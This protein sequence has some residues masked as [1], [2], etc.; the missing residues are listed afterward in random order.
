MKKPRL[1]ICM[2]TY[3]RAGYISETLESIIP[4]LTDE[5]EIVIVDGASTDATHEVVTGYCDTCD[6][7]KYVR[8]A[9]KGGV[10]QDFC[11]A[12]E[13]S[14]GEY[15]WLFP[16]DD[17][18]KPGAIRTVLNGTAKGYSLIVVNAEVSNKNFS[19]LLQD[20]RLPIEQD[21]IY[22][23]SSLQQLFQRVVPY[24]SFIGCVVINRDL[25]MKRERERYFDTEFVHVGVIFQA[26]LPAPALI[27]AEP[28]ISIRFGNAQW[29]QRAFE[30][31]MVKWP[32]L[33][34][35]FA[36]ISWNVG[37]TFE[38]LPFLGRLGQILTLRATGA[39]SLK[40]FNNWFVSKTSDACWRLVAFIIALTPSFLVNFILL[41]F[42]NLTKRNSPMTIYALE[43]N[44]NNI[45]MPRR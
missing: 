23:E 26:P 13:L 9:A 12:V 3:N 33:L 15:C 7:I 38:K 31:W 5:V 27:I 29:S 1:S 44:K 45:L 18:F 17:L 40:E 35:S 37:A 4:Q 20:R 28:Y 34:R 24:I 10:D 32:N 21:E 41:F 42:L 19:R 36:H 11:K 30:I 16:D 43:N 6:R 39:Y 2:A 14:E 8:L 22:N 25:W